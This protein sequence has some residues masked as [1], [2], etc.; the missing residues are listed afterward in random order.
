MSIFE[1]TAPFKPCGDQPASIAR[2]TQ[3]I[4][5][6]FKY[7]T[8]LGVTGSGKTFTVANVIHEVNKPVLVISHNKTLAAQL[9]SELKGFFPHNAV[10]Y[11]V[12]YYDYYQ[13]EAYLPATDTYIEKD[14]SIN[15]E[16]D[17]LRLAATC[18][19]LVR[20]DVII[21]ASVSCIYNIGSPQEYKDAYLFMEIGENFP[22]NN[23]LKR[24]VEIHYERNDIDFSRGKFRVRGDT[25]EIFPSYNE[26][27]AYRIELFGDEV[28]KIC[29][30]NP[31][32]GK[33]ISISNRLLVYPAKHFVTTQS[34]LEQA[35][36]SIEQELDERLTH[37]RGQNKLLESQRLESRTKYDLEILREIGT[38][39]GIENY[40]RHFDGRRPGERPW[41]L[42]D[43]FP[44][45]FLL[46]IDESHVTLPQLRGMYEGDRSRKRNLIDYGFRLPSAHDNRP[47]KFE[48]FKNLMPQ[49]IFVSATPAP[50]ELEISNQVVELIIRPT[51][52]IDP[53][54]DVRKV[55]GQID[56]LIREIRGRVAKKE[57]VLVTTLTKRMAEDLAQY[58][59]KMD[60]KVQYL[61]SEIQ[62]LERVEI[63]RSLRLGEFDVLVGIN[64]LREGLDLPEVS[65]VVILDADKE[66]FL[67][68]ERSLI[69]V[70][71]RTA[72]N[73]NGQVIMYADNITG[74]MKKAID[75]TDRRRK[76]Q[77]EYNE[78]YEITPQTIQKAIAESL[79]TTARDATSSKEPN[80][81]KEAKI[82]YKVKGDAGV[83]IKELEKQM[84]EAAD[85]LEYEKAAMLR[86]EIYELKNQFIVSIQ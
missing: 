16:L 51:G 76:I 55:E 4:N 84:Y 54:I 22:R 81:L 8:L 45:D 59:S 70:F 25:I 64:L 42:I 27:K 15:E 79:L 10:E 67:R 63:L 44:Q 38:C 17:R 30:I 47:L 48:E 86:D 19:L 43:Y 40:S 85:N 56:D 78:M 11:F 49:T 24:L 2:L 35:L 80:Y 39:H 20:Q 1:L 72:R 33:I 23:I 77:I 36:V 13:P 71:G 61:H 82:K 57:R 37:L 12:S 26:D 31:L 75:E 6:G 41:T 73:V 60:I 5:E 29:E 66:G 7:Q 34:R 62:T 58:L 21:V 52:L 3:G 18:S 9:Y 68:S 65:L 50:Y 14:S 32:T 53:A 28:E 83:I 69:Q 46:I 74:S